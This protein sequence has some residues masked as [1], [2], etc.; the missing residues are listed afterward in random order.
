MTGDARNLEQ[1]ITAVI[2]CGFSIHDRLGPGMLESSYE[3]LLEALLAKRGLR[4]QRQKP[5]SLK[6]DEITINDAY[7]VDM[8]V[9]DMLI[10]ELKSVDQ[11]VPLHSKQLLTYLRATGLPVGLLMNFGGVL[12]K[13]G[14]KRVLNNRSDYVAPISTAPWHKPSA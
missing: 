14:V 8:L 9:E 13:T 3:V 7:R 5:I 10:I 2:D 11:L 1:I 4:V 12:F 6:F